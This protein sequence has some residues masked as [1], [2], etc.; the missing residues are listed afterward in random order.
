[1][2]WTN[3]LRLWGGTLTVIVVVALLTILFNQRQ[4]QAASLEAHVDAPAS[5]V[6]SDYGG[7][8]TESFVKEGDRVSA[9]EPLFTLSSLSL[10]QDIANGLEP[11]S[12][13]AYTIDAETGSIT[14]KAAT[15]GYVAGLTAAEGSFFGNGQQ[16]AQVVADGERSVVATYALD[17]VDYGRIDRGAPVTIL[18]PDNSKVVGTVSHARVETEAG[19]TVTEVRVESDALMEPGLESLTRLGTPVV[20]VMQL[21]DEGPLAGPTSAMLAFLTK[22]GL[23]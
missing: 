21:R 3:R 22:V 23:R 8:V 15:D 5:A 1:M 17:P 19:R 13:Q 11:V 2:T 16:M 14:Y 9:G 10:Q 20:A 18:L 7:V 6:G 12:T 4:H